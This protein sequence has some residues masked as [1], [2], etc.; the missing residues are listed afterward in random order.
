MCSSLDVDLLYTCTVATVQLILSI[1]QVDLLYL[2]NPAEMQ[3]TALGSQGFMQRVR[4]AFMWAEGARKQG[5]IRAYG[6]AT[7]DCFRKA[8]GSAGYVSL[9]SFVQLAQQVGGTHHGFR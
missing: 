4:E 6:L 2:H 5:L 1:F 3:L 7:W 8:P 9:M